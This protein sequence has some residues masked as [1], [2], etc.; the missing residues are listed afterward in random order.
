MI[1]DEVTI[2]CI[3]G[4]GGSGLVSFRR[5]KFVPRGGPNGGDGGKGG[6]VIIIAK[7]NTR[8]LTNLNNE[9]IFRAGN[10][11]PGQDDNMH[12]RNGTDLYIPVPVGSQVYTLN[13]TQLLA[14]LTEENQEVV[15]AKGGRGG[16]GNVH[17]VSSRFQAPKIAELGEEGED[18]ELAIE[19][20]LIA[21]VGIIGLPSAGKST[22]ISVI[23]NAKP[24]IAAYHFTTLSPNLGVVDMQ[25]VLREEGASFVVADIPGLIEGASEGKGLGHEFLRHVQRTKTL[26]HI[27]DASEEDIPKAYKV[28]NAELKQYDKN[29]AKKPQVV[30]INK[31]DLVP[32][33]DQKKFLA[34]LQKKLKVKK[35]FLISAAI[36]DGVSD[37][38]KEVWRVLKEEEQKLK[39]ESTDAQKTE[40]KAH[41]TFRPHLETKES[42]EIVYLKKLNKQRYYEIKGKRIEQ[43][44]KMMDLINPQ[45]QTRIRQYL[46]KFGV[47]KALTKKGAEQGD[48]L[49]IAGKELVFFKSISWKK[50]K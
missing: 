50:R 22:L 35:L 19:L 49:V 45:A 12:G 24:K 5:E 41:K 44:V 14:D 25:K 48:M 43:L 18:I 39:E 34:D 30:V 15:I 9:K 11:K 26:I 1:H 47:D 6:S 17:F 32:P 37:L 13:K 28:I 3:G 21:D 20:K 46:K 36:N 7:D 42:F 4:K 33:E 23:S 27:I 8:T 40:E 10:G 38:M 31:K 16:Y 29:L 2:Q